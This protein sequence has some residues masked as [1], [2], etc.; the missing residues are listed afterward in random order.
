MV[1]YHFS[2]LS[3]YYCCCYCCCCCFVSNPWVHWVCTRIFTL[4]FVVILY[5]GIRYQ[6]E[7]T[8]ISYY[9]SLP[10]FH[11][12]PLVVVVIVVVVIVDPFDYDGTFVCSFVRF[13]PSSI[14]SLGVRFP[15]FSSRLIHSFCSLYVLYFLLLIDFDPFVH[16]IL[17][18]HTTVVSSLDL[19]TFGFSLCSFYSMF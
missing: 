7:R 1:L 8:I 14:D 15:S 19:V 18:I 10:L 6:C 4:L 2:F 9:C 3:F 5:Y 17:H 16:F 13:F 11:A 12:I